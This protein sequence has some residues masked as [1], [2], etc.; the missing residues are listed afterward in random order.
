MRL[1]GKIVAV[2]GGAGALG[3]AIAHGLVNQGA[4]VILLDLAA[5]ALQ[6]QARE[7]GA[8]AIALDVRSEFDTQAAFDGL[9]RK[10]GRLDA[11]V[12]CAGVQMHGQDGPAADVGLDVWQK[13]IDVN[14]TGAFLSAKHA[15]PLLVAAQQSS[16]IL[17]GSPTG[18]TMSG[19]GYT[20]Y[21]ASKAGMMALGRVIAADYAHAGVR[22][23]VVVPGTMNTPLIEELLATPEVHDA[24]LAS[25]PIGRL[26]RPEDLVGVTTWLVS[27]ESSFATGGVFAVDGGLTAR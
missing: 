12:I 27:D 1:D 11:I 24:L 5:P 26:G 19:S 6:Q 2:T 10:F 3:G 7:L 22:A 16:L 14:L 8:R 23:N 15:L 20:A 4:T 17:I 25:T 9:E 13:T 18:L 21:A